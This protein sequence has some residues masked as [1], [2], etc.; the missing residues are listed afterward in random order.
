MRIERGADVDA[1]VDAIAGAGAQI[2]SRGGNVVEVTAA[3]GQ[4]NAIARVLDVADIEAFV[5]RKK[6]NEYGGGGIIGSAAANAN[7]FDGSTQT[8]A[9]ADTGLGNGLVSNGFIDVPSARVNA[10]FNWPGAA[11]GCFKSVVNDGA[12]DVDSRPWNAHDR[13]G[14]RIGRA[15]R[16]GT[17]DCTRR[18]PGVPGDRELG[19][20]FFPV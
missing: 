3:P 19:E 12:M 5:L 20:H 1:T 10:I 11:G 2:T 14:A 6:N 4:L 7:G 18:A 15:G 9:V 17:R 13:L 8:V 16:R